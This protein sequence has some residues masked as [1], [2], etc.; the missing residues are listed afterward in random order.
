MIKKNEIKTNNPTKQEYSI[1][2]FIAMESCIGAVSMLASKSTSHKH[3][4]FSDLDWRFVP[5]IMLKQFKVFRSEENVPMAFVSYAK[6]TEEVEKR[7]L[8]GD[9]RLAP[10]DWNSGDRLWI[11]DVI[12]PLEKGTN[13]I[14]K[15]LAEKDFKDQNAKIL[16]HKKDG[17]GVEGMLLSSLVS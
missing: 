15:Q 13:A 8:N 4:F 11:I 12:D 9:L 3:L 5:P 7:I 2:D 14:L 6:V 17:K 16:K 1:P 10:K